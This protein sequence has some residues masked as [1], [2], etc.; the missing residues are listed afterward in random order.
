MTAQIDRK[1]HFLSHSPANYAYFPPVFLFLLF[2]FIFSPLFL[3]GLKSDRDVSPTNRDV[4]QLPDVPPRTTMIASLLAYCG[5]LVPQP[6]STFV[7]GEP[8]NLEARLCIPSW[9]VS[10]DSHGPHLVN[11]FLKRMHDRSFRGMLSTTEF[12]QFYLIA[13]HLP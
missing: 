4:G 8:K 10:D 13:M 3:H 12:I 7:A 5:I 9:I 2:L 6:T 11:K 1:T